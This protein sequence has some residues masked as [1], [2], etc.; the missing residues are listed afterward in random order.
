MGKEKDSKDTQQAILYYR[1]R[2]I[3][4][5]GNDY[6]TQDLCDLIDTFSEAKDLET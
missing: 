1:R 2:R 4:Q 6:T 3:K 5:C